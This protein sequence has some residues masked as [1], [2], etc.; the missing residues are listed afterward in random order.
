MEFMELARS[1]YSCRKYDGRPV[2][3]EDLLA[4]VEAAVLAPSGCNSQPWHFYLVTNPEIKAKM[5]KASQLAPP[6]NLFT[7]E[8]GAMVLVTEDKD[9]RIT[10]HVKALYG[11][12]VFAE[13]DTGRAVGYFC[14]RAYELGLGA[15]ILGL[16]DMDAVSRLLA[17]PDSQRCC[18]MI[19]VGHP[20]DGDQPHPKKR[21]PLAD[22]VTV[23]E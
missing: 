7:D 12:D 16:F 14:L 22:V 11:P 15:C 19:A 17:V 8:A 13:G 4:C 1:R 5:A 10:D 21:L 9:T 20:A 3:K 6:S 23:V 2:A 18:L